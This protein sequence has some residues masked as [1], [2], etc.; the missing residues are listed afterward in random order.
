MSTVSSPVSVR[1]CADSGIPGETSANARPV[2]ILSNVIIDDIVFAD[3][4]QR[5]GV[6]GGAASYSAV[7]ARAWWPNV[8]IVAGVGADLDELSCGHLA[9][10]GVRRE[11]LLV[12]DPHNLRNRLV[13]LANGE[14]TET[15]VAGERHF[16]KLQITPDEVPEV[17]L[18]AVGTY[19]FRDL[20]ENFWRG[21][22]RRREQWGTT[23]W[24]W[25][26]GG[27]GRAHWARIRGMLASIDI[28]SLNLTEARELLEVSDAY[29]LLRQLVGAMSGI[30][31]LRMGADGAL[32]ADR[33]GAIQV[34]PP[35]SHV[36][37]VTGGGNA[38][39]G[40]FLAA[41]CASHDL[42]WSARAAAAAAT[43]AIGGF[44]PPARID[45]K[46]LTA[47]AAAATVIPLD[48][49]AS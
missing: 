22:E 31:V 15:P 19:V 17:L 12:R 36:M 42:A 16:E 49:V 25:Q 8:A 2:L 30:V 29:E 14:R 13:Y 7:G 6:L 48:E 40:A 43:E 18:P 20:A 32:I 38:F 37:D 45:A 26:S 3:G 11:G 27:V 23:L 9:R 21:F 10:L 35:P 4:S 41:W 47:L 34:R 5:S 1:D 33:K 24:E 46:S 44:G 39:C 28:F